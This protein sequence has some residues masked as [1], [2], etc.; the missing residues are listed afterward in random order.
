MGL[1]RSKLN[2]QSHAAIIGLLSALAHGCSSSSSLQPAKVVNQ[3]DVSLCKYSV[4][5]EVEA[6]CTRKR[7]SDISAESCV[8]RLAEKAG[9]LGADAVIVDEERYEGK[10]HAG[11][12][13]V[14]YWCKG[15]AIVWKQQSSG[16]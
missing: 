6:S 4:V 11:A 9:Q 3:A 1:R 12:E 8:E 13:P 7:C 15:R 5:G 10:G 16:S 14:R 2:A